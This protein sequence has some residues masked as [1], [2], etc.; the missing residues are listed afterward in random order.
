[1][2]VS[3]GYVV[4][5]LLFAFVTLIVTTLVSYIIAVTTAGNPATSLGERAALLES[6]FHLRQPLFQGYFSWT[7]EVLHGN[8]GIN[9]HGQS[10]LGMVVPWIVPTVALQLPAI[11]ASVALGLFIGVYSAS[12]AGSAADRAI[13]A[14]SA[15]GFGIPSFWLGIMAILV[16]SF[17]LRLL[18]SFG[19]A[20]PYPPYW[21]GSPSLDLVA[22]YLLPFW[23][24][25]LVST[26]LYIR[27]A[28]ASAVEVLSKDWVMALEVSSVGR[29]RVLYRHVLKNAAGPTLALL[30]YNVAVF[31]AASPGI[32]IAFSWPGLGYGFAHAALSFDYPTMM[33]II[34]LMAL[35]TV[36][37]NFA[38]DLAQAS[39]DPRVSRG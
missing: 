31:L 38:V 24:L 34:L 5:R 6:Y 4:R 9:L 10:V 39:I 33:G 25:V 2:A 17:Y 21:W 14:A 19:Y 3:R 35:V 1:M 36:V 15:L 29:R 30:G 13:N 8:L 26:P 28:R 27:V 12:R 16:F 11:L 20:S 7:W 32:E 18:P 37:S 23:V 22:H